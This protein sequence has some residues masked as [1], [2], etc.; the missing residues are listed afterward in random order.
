MITAMFPHQR[1]AVFSILDS[2]TSTYL[3]FDMGLGKTRVAI[4]VM[5][6][7]GGLR[8][9]VFC[10]SS[11][12]LVWKAEFAK[13]WP[14]A[15][16]RI[17][18]G[19]KD[20]AHLSDPGVTL[21]SY[22]LMSQSDSLYV[23]AIK[24]RQFDMTVLDEAHALKNPG[25][26][27]TKAILKNARKALGFVLPMSGTPAPNHAGELY[28]ILA[29]CFPEAIRKEDGSPMKA[30][31]F[32]NAFCHVVEKRFGRSPRPV[33]VIE[34]SK[35]VD[36]LKQ[37]INGFMLRKR[38]EEVLTDLPPLMFDTVPVKAKPETLKEFADLLK[39]GMSD[40][41]ILKALRQNDEHVMRLRRLIGIA[42][43]PGVI[44][45]L[46]E[47]L[48]GLPGDRKIVV[49]AHHQEVITKLGHA[50]AAWSPVT[51]VGSTLPRDRERVVTTFLNDERSRVFIGNIIAAG[52]A[53]TLVGPK[54][55]CSD[56]FFAETSFNPGDNV[57]AAC[58]VHRIGQRDAVVARLL[59]AHG[60]ID[61]RIQAIL[62]RKAQDF[63]ELFG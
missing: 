41:E 34:G 62:S 28:P 55:R 54:C 10:P 53:L 3:G 26:N 14:E 63:L 35:N 49:F 51:L 30:W 57:Q 38:K 4:E 1:E 20:V 40:D 32:E 5:R 23:D 9:L 50:L 16:V 36:A 13:W 60:T 47:T 39:P 12:R 33:R 43:L 45:Y 46:I 8:H 42:K 56:V 27:R 21:V 6:K 18:G 25:A 37:R 15:R 61:D 24:K 48:D 19:P 52:T 58:R 7:R 11:A 31:E 2:P 59:T 29:S 44:E 22:G 17:L